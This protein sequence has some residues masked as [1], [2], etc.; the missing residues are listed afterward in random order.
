MV[1][2]DSDT[3][4]DAPAEPLPVAEFKREMAEAIPY[5]RAFAR[6]LTG[7]D[8]AADDLTQDALMK[9]WNAR[10]R[11]RAGS[12]FRAWIFTIVRNQFYSNCRRSWRQVA[13]DQEQADRTLTGPSSM[14]GVMELDETRRALLELPDDQREAII[15]VGAGGF[16][17]EEAANICGCAVGT[18]KSRVSR[19]RAALAA[20]LESGPKQ[21]S[22]GDDIK[23]SESADLIMA[24]V[25]S[26][27]SGA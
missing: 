17:Y 10:K 19:A 26:L 5:M 11:F 23:P 15:L 14:N 6:S 24:E 16:S 27:T 18:V 8:S 3:A 4:A 22:A 9:A 1:S 13:W 25:K 7:D 12:N 20:I 21:R 2:P